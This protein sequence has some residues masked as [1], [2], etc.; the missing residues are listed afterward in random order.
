MAV[1]LKAILGFDGKAYEAGLKKATALSKKAKASIGGN[2]KGAILGTLSA[3]Y[4]LS[5]AKEAGQF[6]QELQ[7]M[8]P[9]LGMTTDQLQQWEYVFARAGLELD[10]LGDSLFTIADRTEDALAG[11]ES[12]IEDFRLLGITVDQL[13]GK[14]PQQLFELFADGVQKTTD[15][16]R[17]L[18]AIVRNLGDD[19]GR[20]LTPILMQGAE[21]MKAL[22]EEAIQLGVVVEKDDIGKLADK[23]IELQIAGLRLK[24]FKTQLT[25]TGAEIVKFFQKGYQY[26]DPFGPTGGA[27]GYAFGEFESS[28]KSSLNPMR[29]VD[30]MVG[31]K[32]GWQKVIR[33]RHAEANALDKALSKKREKPKE[34]TRNLKGINDEIE[35]RKA[36]QE[37]QKKINAEAFKHMTKEQQLNNLFHQRLVLFEQIRKASGKAKFELMGKDFDL[38]SQMYGIQT[39]TGKGANKTANTGFRAMSQTASQSVGAFTRRVNPMVQV[40][41]EQLGIMRQSLSVQQQ[42]LARQSRTSNSPY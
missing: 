32:T 37:L 33:Q 26:L 24:S 3:G 31:L 11:T 12:M 22:R 20:K 18:T 16:N 40:G 34:Q 14:N 38:F 10:D 9:A 15:K 19:L 6:A 36:Q 41:R 21:G 8:A 13:R 29:Y 42:I 27:L 2:L 30:A 7:R 25:S 5:Q 39:G 35:A 17:A 28:N 1:N 23:M 4:L